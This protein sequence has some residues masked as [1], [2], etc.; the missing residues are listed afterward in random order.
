VARIVVAF[1]QEHW[2]K[3]F[4]PEMRRE[5]E[6][7]APVAWAD[8]GGRKIPPGEYRGLLARERPEVLVTFWGS[9]RLTAEAHRENPGLRYLCHAGG[10][11]RNYV[12]RECLERG[13]L[14]SNWGDVISRTISEH[15]LMMI[16]ASLR[17]VT[18]T[19]LDMHVR[20]GWSRGHATRSLFGRTV[21]LHGMGPIAQQLVPLLRPFDA[22]VSAC[23][24]H[25]PDKIFEALG[26]RRVPDLE[27]LYGGNDIVSIHTGNTP[28]NFHV[29]NAALLGRMRDGAI[30]VNT[31]RGPI[32]DTAALVAELRTGR[33]YAALD[34]FEEE[35]VPP[36]GG[37]AADSPLRGLE[38]CLLTPHDGGPTPDRLVDCGRLAVDNVARFLRGETVL[39][40]I[41]PA[42]FDAMT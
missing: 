6:G 41:T 3:V 23:S 34:V 4:T 13:L 25:C 29:V 11:L 2:G 37:L 16:L 32:V 28:E 15:T 26:V 9:C 22:T 8:V 20:R 27:T 12:D 7:L 19:T 21:G 38:N 17:N 18:R 33:I 5:L 1:P 35:L 40:R 42:R 36:Y 10:E 30:L 39:N 24:P 31:A 14:V